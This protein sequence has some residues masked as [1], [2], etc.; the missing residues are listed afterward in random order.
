MTL[1]EVNIPL[2][3]FLR[4]ENALELS[5]GDVCGDPPI[6]ALR[7]SVVQI[8]FTRLE[9]VIDNSGLTHARTAVSIRAETETQ[10]AEEEINRFAIRDCLLMANKVITCYQA[11]TAEVSN[12]GYISP[13][14][15]S[16]IQLF[17]EIRVDGKNF[18]D[19]WPFHDMNTV[20]LSAKE[21]GEF[22]SYLL[23]S[24][25]PLPRLL[26]TNALLLLNRGQ[27]SLSVI[28]RW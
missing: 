10:L 9:G 3:S 2:P 12:A 7:G 27:Y 26:L 24:D 6:T 8:N 17:A 11:T 18:R 13:L 14:G 28:R 21:E 25:L 20:P 15:T 23:G 16:D 19:R 22:S 5:Y 1:V 4:L